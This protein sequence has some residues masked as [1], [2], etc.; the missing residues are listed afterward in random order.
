MKKFLTDEQYKLYNLIW[1]RFTASLMSPAVY[2][3]LTIS[4]QAGENISSGHWF[5]DCIS[6][7]FKG[8]N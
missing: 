2:N 3:V 5:T 8:T 6:W 7:I 1:R 4:I